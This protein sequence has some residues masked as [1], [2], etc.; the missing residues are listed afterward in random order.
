MNTEKENTKVVFEP[1]L[2]VDGDRQ[3]SLPMEILSDF[4]DQWKKGVLN[5]D[6]AKFQIY[7]GDPEHFLKQ[8]STARSLE[9]VSCILGYEVESFDMRSHEIGTPFDTTESE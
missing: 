9:I 4:F 3:V 7:Q 8:L 1:R 6:A 2:S 5:Y